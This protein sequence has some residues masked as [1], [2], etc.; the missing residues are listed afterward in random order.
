MKLVVHTETL[1]IK[2]QDEY[3]SEL[4]ESTMRKSW[5]EE[6]DDMERLVKE[7]VETKFSPF[8]LIFCS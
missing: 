1:R 2:L 6:T 8:F 7:L 3:M 4:K 5:L